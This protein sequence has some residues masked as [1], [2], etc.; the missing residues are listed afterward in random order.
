MDPGNSTDR[1]SLP[2]DLQ[3]TFELISGS[4]RL[5]RFK[6]A[7]DADAF[8]TSGIARMNEHDLDDKFFVDPVFQPNSEG[9]PKTRDDYIRYMVKDSARAPLATQIHKWT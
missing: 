4:P 6:A 5:Q 1:Q 2:F 9:K 8:P 3:R 7:A